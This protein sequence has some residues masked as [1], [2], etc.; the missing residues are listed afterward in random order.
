MAKKNGKVSPERIVIVENG[1]DLSE[2]RLSFL[3]DFPRVKPALDSYVEI[4]STRL[5]IAGV[6]DANI[7]AESEY[8]TLPHGTEF[9]YRYF[10]NHYDAATVDQVRQEARQFDSNNVNKAIAPAAGIIARLYQQSGTLNEQQ[11]SRF[12]AMLSSLSL[13]LLLLTLKISGSPGPNYQIMRKKLLATYQHQPLFKDILGLIIDLDKKSEQVLSLRAVRDHQGVE[14]KISFLVETALQIRKLIID[15]CILLDEKLLNLKYNQPENGLTD[16]L[17]SAAVHIDNEALENRH[18]I[19]AALLAAQEIV[20]PQAAFDD[21]LAK[22]A[23]SGGARL[24]LSTEDE[25]VEC[26]DG[27][28]LQR[29]KIRR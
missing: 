7:L 21:Q 3:N 28:Q 12:L 4:C 13:A 25:I 6:A 1:L 10:G 19:E 9:L 15:A 18:K 22:S 17:L 27:E 26:D 29:E 14:E 11:R 16:H 24:R 23:R 5:A 8:L 2:N 20:D